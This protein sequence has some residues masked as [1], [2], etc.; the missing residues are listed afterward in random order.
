MLT[1]RGPFQFNE[2]MLIVMYI[3]IPADFP[4]KSNL[5]SLHGEGR[6]YSLA[7]EMPNKVWPN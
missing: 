3:Q 5:V 1:I 2:T 6:T 4:A 7:L